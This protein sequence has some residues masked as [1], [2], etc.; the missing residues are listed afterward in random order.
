[1]KAAPSYT[2]FYKV[3]LLT[4]FLFSSLHG[5]DPEQSIID[6]NNI[7]SWIRNDGFH[8]WLLGIPGYEKKWNGTFPKGTAGAIFSEGI[9]WGGKVFDRDSVLVRVSGSEWKNGNVPVSRIF[10]VMPF[11]KETDLTDDASNFFDVPAELVTDSMVNQL[12]TQY[13]K[14]WYEWPADKGAPYYDVNKNGSYDP[15]FDIPGIPGASQTIWIN[16]NDSDSP[17][18]FDCPAIGLDIQ[19]T[20]WAYAN[21]STAGIYSDLRNV[22]FK[23]AR[24]IYE[25]NEFSNP[26]SYIDS[27]YIN[28]WVDQVL[29]N[30]SDDLLGCDTSLNMGYVYN[31]RDFDAVY[32]EFLTAPPAVGSVFLQGTAYW[33]GNPLDSAIVNPEPL[34]V[35]I[36]FKTGDSWGDPDYNYQGALEFYNMMRGYRP[37]G[38]TSNNALGPEFIGFGTYMNSGDP[39]T[40][41]GWLDG[42]IDP[43]GERHMYLVNGPIKLKVGDTAEVALALVGGLGTDHLNSITHL[44]YHASLA[45]HLFQIFVRQM[46]DGDL[47]VE[48]PEHLLNSRN[49]VLYQNYPNPFNSSTFIKY[50]LPKPAFVK[51]VVYDIL[52]REVKILVNE[53]KN[54]GSYKAEFNPFR[55]SSGVYIYRISF[56]NISSRLVYDGLT[57][58]NKLLY[59]K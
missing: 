52:G 54:A 12:Y 45:A 32:S 23:H 58:T 37:D 8:D 38:R 24:I 42:I 15:V 40:G 16:Y 20:Y 57:K 26:D 35:F 31:A 14:D 5:Q 46:T 29:G 10:R 19:E 4:I 49:F 6:V 36:A 17:F 22:I 34:T 44:K 59:I 53:M 18:L 11:F 25:G 27:M 33:T 50:Q 30:S 13:E 1:M 21:N 2:I 48:F 41:T 56:N 28:Q 7:T 9:C 51:L 3:Y 55:L 47:K 39:V 43:P